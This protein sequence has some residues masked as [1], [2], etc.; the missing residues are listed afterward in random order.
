[1]CSTDDRQDICPA[2]R[3]HGWKFHRSRRAWTVGTLTRGQAGWVRR[4]CLECQGTG[5]ARKRA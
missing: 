4:S 3:G 5:Q 2:C 1:M